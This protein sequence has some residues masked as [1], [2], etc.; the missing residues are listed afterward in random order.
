MQG[1]RCLLILLDR[2]SERPEVDKILVGTT[3]DP[4]A[5]SFPFSSCI[6]LSNLRYFDKFSQTF[7]EKELSRVKASLILIKKRDFPC[8]MLLDCSMAIE[9]RLEP[10][11]I[12]RPC[13]RSI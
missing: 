1:L 5:S 9:H 7:Q 4:S 13:P 11:P 2:L 10:A 3:K 6:L 12:G 8:L